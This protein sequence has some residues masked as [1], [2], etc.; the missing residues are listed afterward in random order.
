[1]AKKVKRM[2]KQEQY[3]FSGILGLLFYI[4]MMIMYGAEIVW[5]GHVICFLVIVPVSVS[6]LKMY[7]DMSYKRKL[8]SDYKA[9]APMISEESFNLMK[10]YW[11]KIDE[12]LLKL[13]ENQ[14]LRNALND[15]ADKMVDVMM[16]YGVLQKIFFFDLKRYYEKMSY[17]VNF[18]MKTPES[19]CMFV[20]VWMMTESNAD[21]VNYEQ[22]KKIISG[23][24]K[25]LSESVRSKF[26]QLDKF[27]MSFEEDKNDYGMIVL[28]QNS[29]ECSFEAE[30]YKTYFFRL[31]STIAKVDG[32]VSEKEKEVLEQMMKRN[33]SSDEEK[34]R[35]YGETMS[36]NELNKLIGLNSI[37]EAVR[38]LSNLISI[39]QK[40]ESMNLPQP[41]ISY[42]CVFTGNPGTGK[43]TV[44]RILAGIYHDK[45]ILKRGHLVETDRSGLVAE[46]VGQ[47]AV[48]T[49]HIVDKA[50]DG[51]LFI[52]E[53]YSLVS[54]SEEDYGKEAVATL[55]K[56]MEDD[57][58]RLIVILAGY[59]NEMEAFIN[60][61]PGLRSRF[62]RYIEFPDYNADELLEI[63]MLSVRKYEY[64]LEDT[65]KSK[66][67]Q[68]INAAVESKG[69]DFGNARFIR[70]LF[71]KTVERQ[72]NRLAPMPNPKKEDLLIIKAE[73]IP[74]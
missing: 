67:L 1:M 44:A 8:S 43:T 36:E 26:Y 9:S 16:M 37:K 28:I 56:R 18:Y 10:E 71:E 52:D 24:N 42:H 29:G 64:I 68:A 15:S 46:Y 69:K 19:Q 23:Y 4:I 48:K 11:G 17:P 6:F 50:L 3:L 33:E 7:Y 65:A 20:V 5:Y 12:L 32:N 21:E 70:N 54:T 62:N 13:R 14:A 38:S 73:D 25:E 72:A 51:V 57:R 55:L 34:E 59:N 66:L 47:T 39:R 22:Y 60:S 74:E 40:R 30:D 41:K 35:E 58:D 53:A 63:F 49:N 27:V 2:P 61:N 45:G 31:M